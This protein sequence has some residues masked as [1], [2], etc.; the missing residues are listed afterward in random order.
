M[1][2]SDCEFE[3]HLRIIARYQPSVNRVGQPTKFPV[4][5]G[6]PCSFAHDCG[7]KSFSIIPSSDACAISVAH[8]ASAAIFSDVTT[9]PL[10]VVP[11]TQSTRRNSVIVCVSVNSYQAMTSML[12]A[13]PSDSETRIAVFHYAL[14]SSSTPGRHRIHVCHPRIVPISHPALASY[15]PS[16]HFGAITSIHSRSC[17]SV[18][19]DAQVHRLQTRVLGCVSSFHG[20]MLIDH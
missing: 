14:S 11:S 9:F 5:T 17:R 10:N 4:A 8:G 7:V 2:T 19:P 1:P 15:Q 20:A 6:I 12:R 13:L 3:N 18:S 16:V